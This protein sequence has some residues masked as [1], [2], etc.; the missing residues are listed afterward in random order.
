MKALMLLMDQ[1]MDPSLMDLEEGQ[2]L[3]TQV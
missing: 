1:S 3:H 2:A